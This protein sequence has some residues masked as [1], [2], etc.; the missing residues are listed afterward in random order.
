MENNKSSEWENR[1]TKNEKDIIICISDCLKKE[2]CG[3]KVNRMPGI[4]IWL[5]IGKI[6]SGVCFCKIEKQ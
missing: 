5:K 6:A 3:I 1:V 4:G 2:T